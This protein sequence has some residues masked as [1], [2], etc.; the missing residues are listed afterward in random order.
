MA[1]ILTIDDND[2]YRDYLVAMLERAG[3][4]VSARPNGTGLEGLVQKQAFDVVLTDLY[5]PEADGIETIRMLRRLLPGLPVLGMTGGMRG[6]HSDVT[7]RS[8][9]LFGAKAV[10]VKPI[11]PSALLA[12]IDA[13]TSGEKVAS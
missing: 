10:F 3:H 9:K 5:M 1:R 12:A 7:V 11:E 13:V 6:G 8:M 4:A 2:D